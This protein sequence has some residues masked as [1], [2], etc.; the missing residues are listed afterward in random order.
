M[1]TVVTIVQVRY[2]N[3]GTTEHGHDRTLAPLSCPQYPQWLSRDQRRQP[4][5]WR[6]NTCHRLPIEM[7]G[8]EP[9][10]GRRRRRTAE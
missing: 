7:Q 1:V 6:A 8:T 5:L 3:G 10:F 9:N 4:C 2:G